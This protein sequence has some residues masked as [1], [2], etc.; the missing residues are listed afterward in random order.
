LNF[1]QVDISAQFAKGQSCVSRRFLIWLSLQLPDFQI[2]FLSK[3]LCLQGYR[4]IPGRQTPAPSDAVSV[5]EG[6]KDSPTHGRQKPFYLIS[7][8]GL[9]LPGL[10]LCKDKGVKHCLHD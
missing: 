10:S 2:H 1:C 7:F 3:W 5:G 6:I 4:S 8:R 9:L